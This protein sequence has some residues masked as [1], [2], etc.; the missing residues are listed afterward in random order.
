MGLEEVL[1]EAEAR[2]PKGALLIACI[3]VSFALVSK[4]WLTNELQ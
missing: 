3:A 1:E 2:L 4:N